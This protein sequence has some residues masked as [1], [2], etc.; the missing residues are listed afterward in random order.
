VSKL[1]SRKFGIVSEEPHK[2]CERSGGTS[3]M[4]NALRLLL[5]IVVV[6]TQAN[7]DLGSEPKTDCDGD[8]E[9]C[10]N[11]DKVRMITEEELSM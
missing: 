1:G 9:S 7:D 6:I 5:A 11:P 10:D 8:S 2:V 3:N 4:P